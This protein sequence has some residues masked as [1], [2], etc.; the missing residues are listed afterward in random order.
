MKK[1]TVKFFDDD[2][3]YGFI[4][5]DGSEKEHF[6]HATGCV[7]RITKGDIVEF[8]LAE[9]QKGINAVNVKIAQ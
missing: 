1:G 3:R 9:G 8:E 7:D 6:V 5:E 2:K 4:Q